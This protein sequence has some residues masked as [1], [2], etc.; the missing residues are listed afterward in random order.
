MLPEVG[1]RNATPLY[2]VQEYHF[3]YAQVYSASRLKRYGSRCRYN[4]SCFTR[5]KGE[6]HLNK[7]ALFKPSR[8]DPWEL[9]VNLD[10]APRFVEVTMSCSY[11]AYGSRL[12]INI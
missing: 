5:R 4:N 7:A 2:P 9:R 1:R 6:I 3:R 10:N 11:F 12:P 8:Q